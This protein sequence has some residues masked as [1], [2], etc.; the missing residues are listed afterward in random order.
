MRGGGDV[1]QLVRDRLHPRRHEVEEDPALEAE[2]RPVELVVAD[3]AVVLV[4]AGAGEP[5]A[6]HDRV[7]GSLEPLERPEGGQ[8]HRRLPALGARE[9]VPARQRVVHIHLVNGRTDGKVVQYEISAY[10]S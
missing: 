1:A 3:E 2:R 5:H 7:R 6:I 10:R 8:R 4:P 9:R